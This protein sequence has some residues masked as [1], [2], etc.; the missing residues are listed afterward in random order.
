M[1]TVLQRLD[2]VTGAAS[3]EDD[4]DEE[5]VAG[6]IAIAVDVTDTPEDNPGLAPAGA[7]DGPA[8][9]EVSDDHGAP[10]AFRGGGWGP[11]QAT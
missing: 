1:A 6:P 4:S 7:G 11:A 8:S 2:T 10:C 3:A 9:D 5:T